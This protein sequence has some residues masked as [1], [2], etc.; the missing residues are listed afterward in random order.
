MKPRPWQVSHCLLHL[1]HGTCTCCRHTQSLLGA[2]DRLRARL[3]VLGT[4]GLAAVKRVLLEGM[5]CPKKGTPG[6]PHMLH[7]AQRWAGRRAL[8]G[9]GLRWPPHSSPRP[10][11]PAHGAGAI[12][13]P[14][15]TQSC[16]CFCLPSLAYLAV[17]ML[18]MLPTSVNDLICSDVEQ[19][20]A[21][22]QVTNGHLKIMPG[23]GCG[24]SLQDVPS[25]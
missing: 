24:V 13:Q 15:L 16:R 3:V 21:R 18:C 8:A 10:V 7:V 2:D 22:A 4:P 6:R 25:A 20:D 9:G 1:H 23:C 17:V 12:H 5:L 19:D 11:Q 14:A